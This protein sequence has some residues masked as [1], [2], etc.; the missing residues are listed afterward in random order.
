MKV[1]FL[2]RY[3]EILASCKFP[4]YVLYYYNKYVWNVDC[5]RRWRLNSW[6]YILVFHQNLTMYNVF[7]IIYCY[8][9]YYKGLINIILYILSI[10]YYNK[11]DILLLHCTNVQKKYLIVYEYYKQWLLTKSYYKYC[12]SN[13]IYRNKHLIQIK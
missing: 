10:F 1:D 8:Y 6:K 4:E 7:S 2:R 3:T 13:I 9:M 5:S 11:Y 12:T